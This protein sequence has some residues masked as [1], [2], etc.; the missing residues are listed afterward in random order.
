MILS[1]NPSIIGIT[2][3]VFTAASLLPQLFKIIKEKKAN[4]ISMS[5]LLVLFTGLCFWIWYGFLK[6]DWA[7]IVTNLFSLLVN[8]LIFIFS[9]KYKKKKA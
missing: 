7:I 2:A 1:I 8:I 5:M 4:D 6:K 9:V 3:G